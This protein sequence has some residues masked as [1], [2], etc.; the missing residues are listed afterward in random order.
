MLHFS[1]PADNQHKILCNIVKK[2]GISMEKK[3]GYLNAFVR[4]CHRFG[5]NFGSKLSHEE[6]VCW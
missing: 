3:L 5:S 1:D 2:D 4:F 6:V